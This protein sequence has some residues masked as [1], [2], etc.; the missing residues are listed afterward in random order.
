MRWKRTQLLIATEAAPFIFTFTQQCQRVQQNQLAA[1]EARVDNCLSDGSTADLSRGTE[2]APF[3][4]DSA[5][6]CTS[7]SRCIDFCKEIY[8]PKPNQ[9]SILALSSDSFSRTPSA[10]CKQTFFVGF[11]ELKL[12]QAARSFWCRLLRVGLSSLKKEKERKG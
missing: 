3:T 1:T 10:D 2:S 11:K 4:P 12:K 6:V 8:N 9:T 7:Q 5:M